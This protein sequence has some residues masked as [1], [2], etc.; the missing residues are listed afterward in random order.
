[1]RT[2]LLRRGPSRRRRK[3][4]SLTVSSADRIRIA[5]TPSGEGED[6]EARWVSPRSPKYRIPCDLLYFGSPAIRCRSTAGRAVRRASTTCVSHRRDRPKHGG[7]P[8]LED[9]KAETSVTVQLIFPKAPPYSTVPFRPLEGEV[10]RRKLALPSQVI[11]NPRS[12]PMRF[13]LEEGT[14]PSPGW[15]ARRRSLTSL[16]SSLGLILRKT[17]LLSVQKNEV[18]W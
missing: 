7:S 10:L 5:E 1:L 18:R 6:S 3:K 17:G 16:P 13:H 4:G 11:G 2:S 8:S 9:E 15:G 12:A 14:S